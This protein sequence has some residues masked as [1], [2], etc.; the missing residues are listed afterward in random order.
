MIDRTRITGH[1]CWIAGLA[2]LT[3]GLVL[4]VRD[5][6]DGISILLAV[7]GGAVIGTG[8]ARLSRTGSP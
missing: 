8:L 4:F 2:M 5:E 6:L 1:A 3:T 7:L